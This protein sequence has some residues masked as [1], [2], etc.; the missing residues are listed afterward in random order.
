M[1]FFR[2][3]WVCPNQSGVE[4]FRTLLCGQSLQVRAKL[5]ISL[6]FGKIN[7]VEQSLD[8]KTMPPVRKGIF[9]QEQ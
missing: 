4:G 2:C 5:R 6:I 1:D 9:P 7:I 8:I 3:F